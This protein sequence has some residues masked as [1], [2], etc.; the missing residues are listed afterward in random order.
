MNTTEIDGWRCAEHEDG[1]RIAQTPTCVLSTHHGGNV[2][3]QINPR[4]PYVIPANVLRW[5][6]A[7][8]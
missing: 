8:G 7:G 2:M 4:V 1:Q 5:L 6:L 3:V